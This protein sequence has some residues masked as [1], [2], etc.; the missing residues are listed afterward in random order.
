[1]NTVRQEAI[2]QIL[3]ARLASDQRTCGQT[4]D[5]VVIDD[6]VELVGVCDSEEQRSVARMIAL[7][8]YG[9]SVVN[10]KL[11]VRRVAACV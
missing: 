7:G 9:V 3:R 10:D 11:Q 6:S 4:I 1:M 8:T 5:I 2:L